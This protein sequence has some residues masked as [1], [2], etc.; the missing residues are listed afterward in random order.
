M[1]NL[2]LILLELVSRAEEG[3]YSFSNATGDG[4]EVTFLFSFV[5]DGKAYLRE[6]DI[7][8]FVR[9]ADPAS[10]TYNQVTELL[11]EYQFPTENSITLETVVPT[12]LDGVPNIIIRRIMPKDLPYADASTDAIFRKEVLNNSFLQSLY[13]VHEALDGFIG[14]AGS[15]TQAVKGSVKI[16]PYEV[17]EDIL[18]TLPDLASRLNSVFVW[19]GSGHIHAIHITDFLDYVGGSTTV[20]DQGLLTKSIGEAQLALDVGQGQ[21]ILVTDDAV[22]IADIEYALIHGSTQEAPDDNLLYARKNLSWVRPNSVEIVYNPDSS[23][24]PSINNVRDAI[25]LNTLLTLALTAGTRYRGNWDATANVPPIDTLDKRSG[26]YWIVE[27]AGGTP[28]DDPSGTPLTG[29]VK[30]EK[31]IWV[32][33]DDEGVQVTGWYRVPVADVLPADNITYDNTVHVAEFPEDVTPPLQVQDKLDLDTPRLADSRD[34]IANVSNPHGVT[35][36]Q[37]G[38]ATSAQGALAD[39]ATQPLDNVSTLTNDAGYLTT[40][41]VTN[42]NGRTGAI[43]PEAGD[44]PPSLIG[45]SPSVHTHTTAEVTGLDAE[46]ASKL[47]TVP[48]ATSTTFGG[49]KYTFSGGVLNLITV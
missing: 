34:H 31:A 45:A 29:W 26:D 3:D 19:N 23:I 24:D 43:E 20:G 48:V 12:P 32:D 36:A 46:L 35:P 42:F 38:G 17:P 1:T 49:F 18:V 41:P 21:G 39:S 37:I 15:L 44:Y 4:V 6:E 11:E 8:A 40:V 27:V 22:A 25:R 10:P 47:E 33:Y 5:G 30:G 9:D 7:H 14:S 16:P 13:V 28:L 2:E